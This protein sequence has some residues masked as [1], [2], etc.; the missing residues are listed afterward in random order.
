MSQPEADTG[1]GALERVPS[2][3]PGL[4][5]VLCGGFL[6]GGLYLVQGPPGA[7]KTVL[8]SQVLYS[9]AAADGDRA[10][11][12]TVLGENHG[13]MLAHLR[14]MRFFD[15]A[16]L[17][18]R[19]TYISAYQALD[20]DGLRGLATLLRREVQGRGAT[21]LVL[22]GMS[23]VGAKAGAGFELKRLTHELQTLASA[24]SCTMLLLTT[25]SGTT[26]A[27]EHTMVDGLIELRQRLYGVRSERRLLVHKFRGGGF[28]EGEHAYRITGEGVAVFPRV[29]ALLATPTRREPPPATRVPSGAASFDA[30]LGGGIPAA[31]MTAVVGPSG[32]GK[33]T[34]GLQFLALSGAAEPGLLFGCY[35]P[36][37]RL[38]L[39]AAT[40]GLDL[41]AAERRGDVEILWH[42]TGEHVLDGLAHR[43]LESV[44]RR[45]VKRLV[46]DGVSGFQQAAVEPERIVRFWSALSNELRALG[47]TTLH[48]LEMPELI[49]AEVRVPVGGMSSLA[50]V[51]VLLR[52]V[53]LRSRL[54]RLVSLFKVREGA[55][56]PTIREFAITEAGIVVGQPFEGVEAVLSGMAR[57][58]ARN[59]AA[60]LSEDHD[61]GS[62]GGD[63]ARPG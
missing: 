40:M 39:K 5:A 48:T 55:F 17:P 10:L 20:D 6:R 8:G 14:A 51:M 49:G 18:E 30:M 60:A 46:I 33:T 31:T 29:E 27:P 26:T 1:E 62:F 9:R 56:D 41:A 21:L 23:A 2:R 22:D 59:A 35:E 44:R 42:P 53:E 36:P 57:E 61:Q 45:G 11:F 19:V 54:F 37:E 28:L 13:R 58:A 16:L 43:L 12:V 25:T 47:A 32:A 3:V 24:T 63:P 38:R 15:P 7:G 34:L 52:Y 50:E 4:D